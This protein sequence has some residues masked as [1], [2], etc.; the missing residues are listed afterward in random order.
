MAKH[1][2][3]SPTKISRGGCLCA[4]I[5]TRIARREKS[6]PPGPMA[7]CHCNARLSIAEKADAAARFDF[8]TKLKEA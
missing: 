2:V 8:L 7:L 4:T 6:H 3:L 5:T 1:S